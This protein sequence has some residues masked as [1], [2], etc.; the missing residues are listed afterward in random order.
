ML[1]WYVECVFRDDE[2]AMRFSKAAHEKAARTHDG[3]R[4]LHDLSD[5]YDSLTRQEL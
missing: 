2:L 5:I 1:A 4:S 3:E